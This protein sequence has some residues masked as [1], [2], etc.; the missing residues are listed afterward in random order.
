[1]LHLDVTFKK[2]IS[3]ERWHYGRL[4]LPV[5]F[6]RTDPHETQNLKRSRAFL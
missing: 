1:M 4:V 2:L 3:T 6:D 5:S